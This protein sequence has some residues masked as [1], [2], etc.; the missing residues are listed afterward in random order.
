M[1][2]KFVRCAPGVSVVADGRVE[3]G[4]LLPLPVIWLTTEV[5][6]WRIESNL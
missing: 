5:T 4:E 1:L 2:V 3:D 6:G